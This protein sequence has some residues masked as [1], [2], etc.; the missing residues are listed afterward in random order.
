MDIIKKNILVS[1]ITISVRLV[2]EYSSM[3]YAVLPTLQ[4]L[5]NVTDFSLK[6]ANS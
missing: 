4:N 5:R 1:Y 2:S 6:I 3:A